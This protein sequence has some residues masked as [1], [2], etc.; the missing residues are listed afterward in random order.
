MGSEK[1]IKGPEL[2][3]LPLLSYPDQSERVEGE[4]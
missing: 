3:E 2:L 1:T 4:S